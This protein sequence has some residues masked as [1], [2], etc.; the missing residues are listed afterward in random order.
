M[1]T[2]FN[3]STPGPISRNSNSNSTFSSL[4]TSVSGKDEKKGWMSSDEIEKD[5]VSERD[6]PAESEKKVEQDNAI[7]IAHPDLER[8]ESS[9]QAGPP[10]ASLYSAGDDTVYPEGGLQAWLVVFGSFCG[11]L[12]AFGFMNSSTSCHSSIVY[13]ILTKPQSESSKAT[14]APIN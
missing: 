6:V 4:K 11:M 14:S 9:W 10:A 12:S 5:R 7:P 3:G 8:Q 1:S 2:K 13:G